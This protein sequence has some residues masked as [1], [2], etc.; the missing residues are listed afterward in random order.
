[1]SMSVKIDS[2][3]DV[4]K[5]VLIL[6]G[7]LNVRATVAM[8]LTVMDSSVKVR[9]LTIYVYANRPSNSRSTKFCIFLLVLLEVLCQ[10][11]TMPQILMNVHWVR[12]TVTSVVSIL[13]EA[14]CVHVLEASPS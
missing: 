11:F 9:L 2:Q 1:M 6:W 14:L 10:A 3:V 5:I 13:K 8:S 12:T 4:L 7:A